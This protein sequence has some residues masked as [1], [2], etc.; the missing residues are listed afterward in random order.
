MREC[1]D[2]LLGT[3]VKPV[4]QEESLLRF[5]AV[6]SPDV[7]WQSRGFLR[8]I[9]RLVVAIEPLAPEEMASMIG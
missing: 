4:I 3:P 2:L 1:G 9:S 6:R 5:Q 8:G 7:M